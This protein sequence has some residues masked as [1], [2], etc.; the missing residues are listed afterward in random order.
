M[1]AIKLLMWTMPVIFGLAVIVIG[2]A[3]AAGHERRNSELAFIEEGAYGA[4][5]RSLDVDYGRVIDIAFNAYDSLDWSPDG[6]SMVYTLARP[7]QFTRIYSQNI[8][9]GK[10]LTLT[11]D[12]GDSF[13]PAW[14]PNGQYLAFVSDEAAL[15]P[16]IYVM[17]ADGSDKRWVSE[18]ENAIALLWSPDSRHLAFIKNPSGFNQQERILIVDATSGDPRYLTNGAFPAWS[19]DGRSMAYIAGT[20]H[21]RD[22]YKI[23]LENGKADRLTQESALYSYPKWSSD[24]THIAFIVNDRSNDQIQIMDANGKHSHPLTNTAFTDIVDFAW[25]PDSTRVAFT[26]RRA[27]TSSGYDPNIPFS[28]YLVNADGS[29]L[30]RILEGKRGYDYAF[31]YYHALSWRPNR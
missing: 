17:K 21:R 26:A 7:N 19:P 24:G 18:W 5:I 31:S 20:A 11:S 22:V 1:L 2:L 15:P 28:L 10:T 9:T 4:S 29:N 14:S 6:H 8:Y 25:S 3:Q 23:D 13:L 16:A 12:G 27:I 30:R